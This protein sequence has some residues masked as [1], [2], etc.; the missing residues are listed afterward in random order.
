MPIFSLKYGPMKNT[1]SAMRRKH[2]IWW[3]NIAAKLNNNGYKRTASQRKIKIHNLEQKYKKE[4]NL[5]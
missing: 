3:E 4:K 2:N 5:D 1:T